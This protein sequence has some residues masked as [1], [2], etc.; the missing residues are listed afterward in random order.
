[1]FDKFDAFLESL[2]KAQSVNR[3]LK[4]H[5]SVTNEE[6]GEIYELKLKLQN[7][8]SEKKAELG[9]LLSQT[10]DKYKIKVDERI[11]QIQ[12][13]QEKDEFLNFDPSLSLETFQNPLSRN[14]HPISLVLEEILDIFKNIGFDIYDGKQMQTQTQ[15]FTLVGTPDYH[16]AR[17]MQDTFFV[18]LKDEKNENYVMRTQVT[19]NIIEYATV[20][21]EN[22]E[23]FRVVFPGLAFRA[24]N[25]DSTHDI[26]FHQLDF[27]MVGKDYS[28]AKL[29]ELMTYILQEFFKDNTIKVRF[30]P[31][32]F[33]F[34]Q[35]SYEVD[36]YAPW[37]KG[38]R[39]IEIAG[40]GP[41]HHNV[42]ENI[43][44]DSEQFNGLAAGFG[45][46]RLAQLKLGVET[47]P[48]FYNGNLNFL[49]G[50]S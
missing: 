22:K 34:T 1:M 31:S 43:G 32:Y 37:F 19:A 16:P 14:M 21:A 47:L 10:R 27:W 50:K 33:P 36:F 46:T 6:G 24:E 26:N 39:W 41:I 12:E 40:C 7:E 23:N 49:R 38:G 28:N 15:N 5:N 13:E 17:G 11:K 30:R 20:Y 2:S 3:C 29:F 9:K 4:I 48:E 44:L 25:M 8:K 18:D 42:I 45:L 35:P